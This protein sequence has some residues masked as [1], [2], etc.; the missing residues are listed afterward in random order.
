MPKYSRLRICQHE[1]MRV[2]VDECMIYIPDRDPV[3]KSLRLGVRKIFSKA[4]NI[5]GY[6][7]AQVSSDDSVKRA[8]FW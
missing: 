4:T 3:V 5:T 2:S 8:L 6:L 7:Q 1:R